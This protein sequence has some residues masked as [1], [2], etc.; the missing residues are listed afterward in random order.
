MVLQTVL[1]YILNKYLGT[2]VENLDANQLNVGIWGGDVELKNLV[3]KTSALDELDLPVEIVYGV[4]EKLVLKIPWK[5]VYTS[6]SVVCLEGIY[7]LLQ[8]NQQVQYD[9][10]KEE[11]R[12]LE[13]KMK[14]IQRIEEAKK[15]EADKG[16]P[17][18][19]LGWTQE[20]TQKLVATIIKNI[21]LNI[22]NIHVRYEDRVTNQ[23]NPFSL[24][25]TLSELIVESTD[26]NWTRTIA[27]DITKIYKVPVFR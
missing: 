22:K 12:K 8:P 10:V 7:L 4:I 11:K 19:K 3:L 13:F 16:K 21:Q 1:S 6:P 18:S 2:F 9:E 25:T 5:T 14:E 23:K 15:T 24:G 20:F 26:S 17:S 27:E